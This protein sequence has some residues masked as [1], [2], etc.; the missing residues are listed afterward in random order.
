M[1]DLYKYKNIR[2]KQ[3]NK[4]SIASLK[5]VSTFQYIANISGKSRAGCCVKTAAI[6]VLKD[7]SYLDI[8]IQESN[9]NMLPLWTYRDSKD[10]FSHFQ[11]P[12]IRN[13]QLLRV[14]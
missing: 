12:H 6:K 9:S 5:L 1:E 14:L 2:G 11:G 4:K 3:S 10:I 8:A 13:S 7:Y